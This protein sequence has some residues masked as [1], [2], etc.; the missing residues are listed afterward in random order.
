VT[1]PIVATG[2]KLIQNNGSDPTSI[3]NYM[4]AIVEAAEESAKNSMAGS[5]M[6]FSRPTVNLMSVSQGFRISFLTPLQRN[7]RRVRPFCLYLLAELPGRFYHELLNKWSY[8][9]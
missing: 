8:C 5:T 1:V 6:V 4:A 2:T 3:I 9:V 7:L